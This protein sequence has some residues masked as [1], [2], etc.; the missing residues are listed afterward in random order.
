MSRQKER[1][2]DPKTD[3]QIRLPVVV[4]MARR[5]RLQQV[6]RR[7]TAPF[8][9]CVGT[10]LFGEPDSARVLHRY[11][12]L[13]YVLGKQLDCLEPATNRCDIVLGRSEI[14]HMFLKSERD[15]THLLFWDEDV[16]GTPDQIIDCLSAMLKVDRLIVGVPYPMKRIDWAAVARVADDPPEAL[17]D[18]VTSSEL[19]AAAVHYAPNLDEVSN[20][21]DADG[22]VDVERLP[23]GFSLIKRSTLE[24]ATRHYYSTLAYWRPGQP[25]TEKSVALFMPCITADGEYR[26]EDYAFCERLR[27]MGTTLS[28]Y[29]GKG[30]PLD[31]VGAHV[32]KG[33]PLALRAKWPKLG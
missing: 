9:I 14:V 1:D 25:M 27:A 5:S 26:G 29:V 17:R 19:E 18:P 16:V 13:L 4:R 11:G 32:F 6:P 15:Y 10:P 20:E 21:P 31:H 24:E 8:R 28:L 3:P 7:M 30:A 33:S 22:C 23:I 12:A 2:H